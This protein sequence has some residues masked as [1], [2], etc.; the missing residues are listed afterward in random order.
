[1]NE[2]RAGRRTA[3][4]VGAVAL[5]VG[6]VGGACSAPP[7]RYVAH[8]S[9]KTYLK[10]PRSW[11]S[12]D[13]GLLDQADAKAVQLAGEPAPSFVDTYFTGQV[14]W[15]E[16]FDADPDPQPAHVVSFA[17]A[18]V[19]E[20]RVRQLTNDERDKVTLASLRNIFFPYDQLKAEA[21][22]EQ[23][24]QPLEANPPSTGA[25]R[26]LGEAQIN[27]AD[28]VRGNRIRFE[29]RQQDQV[30]VV[31]Q[32]A[33]LDASTSHVYVLLIRAEEHRYLQDFNQLNA[34]ADSF[35]VKQKG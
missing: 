35:T 4:W 11:K 25:F 9:T 19:V 2:R 28:G 10:V 24:G 5:A 18:P 20:V 31:D 34:V 1:M 3:G 22:L 23:A 13:G 17:L 26:S 32:T 33:L 27:T 29:L 21:D 15:R 30:F 14:Q 16:A 8:S 12:F 6:L 7:Y